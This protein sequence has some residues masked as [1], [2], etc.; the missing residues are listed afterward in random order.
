MFFIEESHSYKELCTGLKRLCCLKKFKYAYNYI[1][2]KIRYII[3]H[4]EKKIGGLNVF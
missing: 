2:W 1:G 4:H 3:F